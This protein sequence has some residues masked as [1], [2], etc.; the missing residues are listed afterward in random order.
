LLFDLAQTAGRRS[1]Y[2]ISTEGFSAAQCLISDQ[3]FDGR[4]K[5][6]TFTRIVADLE[7]FEEWLWNPVLNFK[8]G[9][10]VS[11]AKYR[12]PKPI[13][14]RLRNGRLS[15]IQELAGASRGHFDLTWSQS[16]Y[17]RF[18]P[19]KA[20]GME[21]V[22]EWYR[23]L[24]DLMI[25][26]TDSDYRLKWPEVRWRKYNCTLYFQWLASKAERP[27]F[28]ECPM[29]FPKLRDDFRAIFGSWLCVRDKYGPGV[30]NYLS[31][32][33]GMQMYTEN[34][35]IMLIS[36]VE[37]FHHTKYGDPISPRASVKLDRIVDQIAGKK[38]KEWARK[39]L[40]SRIEPN[41]S[42]RIFGT[43]N[44]LSLGF[45][46]KRLRDFADDCA[47]LRNDLAHYGGNRR[48]TVP[49]SDF[50]SS[51]QK[52]NNALRPLYHTFVLME[53]GLDPA[54]VRAW[55][56][57]RPQAYLRNWYFAEVGLIDHP[58]SNSQSAGSTTVP[59][60]T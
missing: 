16:A 38:D 49:Y 8:Y 5:Q 46:E 43:F 24:Q 13:I 44:A 33:R 26:L 17:L 59:A 53:I 30:Y 19:D 14:Y 22:I 34:Q 7:G 29:I 42:D 50:L 45:D 36:G 32:R 6:P 15:L 60:T 27:R 55:A 20:M 23:W 21:A 12:K 28:S 54:D 47:R 57:E 52:K 37:S 1:T 3:Q 25:L 18:R 31:T 11:T 56:V 41:L 39:G 35:F 51:V 4:I 48:K 40:K 2:T 9:K 10:V 58:D